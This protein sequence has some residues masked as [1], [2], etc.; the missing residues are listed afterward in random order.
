MSPLSFCVENVTVAIMKTG[1][2]F[3]ISSP[4]N[5]YRTD[6]YEIVIKGTILTRRDFK[7]TKHSHQLDPD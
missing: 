3:I 6:V 5:Y 7:N 1:R 4:K 2:M